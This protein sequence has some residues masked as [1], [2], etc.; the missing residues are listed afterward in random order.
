MAAAHI[1]RS[2][3]HGHN[4][5]PSSL[6]PGRSNGSCHDPSSAHVIPL[7]DAL[8]DDDCV[9]LVYPY[10]SGGDLFDFVTKSEGG[11]SEETAR[12]F[13][14]D[15]VGGLR[16]LKSKG[17]AHGDV[18]LE[19]VVLWE[20]EEAVEGGSA[21]GEK[22]ERGRPRKRRPVCRLTDLEMARNLS[23]GSG[24]S[25]APLGRRT[26]GGKKGY[27][28]PEC[29]FGTVVDWEAADVW[30]LGVSLYTMLTRHPLYTDPEDSGFE[31]LCRGEARRMM[32]FYRD[33]YSLEISE[34]AVDLL[35][36]MLAPNPAGRPRLEEVH[37]HAWLDGEGGKALG[38]TEGGGSSGAFY[39]QRAC[40]KEEMDPGWEGMLGRRP[41]A[42]KAMEEAHLDVVLE[43][44]LTDDTM[45]KTLPGTPSLT[46]DLSSA[47]TPATTPGSIGSIYTSSSRSN[48][49]SDNHGCESDHTIRSKDDVANNIFTPVLISN[50][51]ELAMGQ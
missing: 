16:Y 10:A 23:N 19:N 41:T 11:L 6:G 44:T 28:A 30:S 22:E 40:A 5:N 4:G 47:W 32:E 13:F 20:Q 2:Y 45:E 49:S 24:P 12:A 8:A 18:S 31:L 38:S 35:A 3:S 34:A 27:V 17:L 50:Y 9:Y 48:S 37:E 7:L 25:V 26:V 39:V 21:G 43:K 1:L 15:M 29:V 14:A 42:D 33:V 36:W 51:E 46:W